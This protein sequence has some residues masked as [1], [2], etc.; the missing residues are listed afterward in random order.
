[1]ALLCFLLDLR[2]LPP[3][4]LSGL[5]DSLLQL[6]NLYAISSSSSAGRIGLCYVFKNASSG[7]DDALLEVAY[8]PNRSFSLRDFHRAVENLPTDAFIPQIND[9]VTV[10]GRDVK[11]SAVL[12]DQVLYSWGGENVKRKVIVLSAY[13]H[14]D[15][16]SHLEKTLMEAANMRVSVEFVIFKQK[17]SHLNFIEEDA[18][19]LIRRISDIDG[20]SLELYL[21]DVRV[22]QSLVRQWLHDLKDDMK[23]PLIACFDFKGNLIYSTNQITCNLYMTVTQMIDGFPPCQTCRCH[24][25]PLEVYGRKEMKESSCAIS[26]DFLETSDVMKNTTKVGE[27]SILFL[28]SSQCLTKSQLNSSQIKFDIIQRTNLGTL[29]ESVIMGASYVVVP[30][31]ES[32]SA[33]NDEFELNALAFRGLC[34]ALHSLDQGLVCL[35]NWNMETLNESTFPCYYILQPSQNGSMFLRRLAGSEEVLYVPDIKTLITAHVCQEIQSSILVSLEK[36]E[37]K[38][39]NPLM[40]E[41]GLHQKLNVLVKESLEFRSLTPRSEEGTY[42]NESNG[43]DYLKGIVNSVK[44]VEIVTAMDCIEAGVAETWEQL[45]THEFPETCPVYVSKDKLDRLSLSPPD[46]NKQLA[47]KTSRILERLEI[48]RQRT[49][50][51]SPNTISIDLVDPNSPTKKPP[52]P[53]VP[54]LARDQGFTGTQTQLM[55]PNFNKLKRKRT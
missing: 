17:S 50:A 29:C 20:C 11:L 30:S 21:P 12:S 47:V 36:V 9:Y 28:P 45:V 25:M 34:G 43:P 41:R 32:S 31:S 33:G 42:G 3:P 23:E 18:N 6:A 2:T 24:G 10:Y 44:D 13:A 51:T 15:L 26:G 46:G 14:Y 5:T 19:G 1:M 39:Y 54:V 22:F 38:D 53:L 4:I 27:K 35:S 48:P 55:K 7:P 16:D 37:L 52:I 8:T 40:H 49:K